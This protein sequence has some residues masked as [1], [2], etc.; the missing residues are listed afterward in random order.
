VTFSRKTRDLHASPRHEIADSL[1]KFT[2]IIFAKGS[3][4][5]TI[6]LNLLMALWLGVASLQAHAQGQVVDQESHPSPINTF[7]EGVDGLYLTDEPNEQFLQSFIPSLSAIDF[8]AM[9]FEYGTGTAT[10]DVNLYEG[11]PNAYAATLLGTTTAVTMP[12]EFNNNGLDVAGVQDFH[13]T[14]PIT[15]TPGDTYY[16]EPILVSGGSQWSFVTIIDYN[17]YPNGELY[18]N[19]YPFVNSTEIWFKEGIEAVPE[20]TAGALTGVAC[21]VAWIFRKRLKLPKLAVLVFAGA[22]FSLPVLSINA[23]QDSVVQATADAA[24]LTPVS[25]TSPIGTFWVAAVNPNGGGCPGTSAESSS[26]R[27]KS[28]LPKHSFQ[29]SR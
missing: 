27:T 17:T 24:G 16:L 13:F 22:L 11:S 28:G 2:G 12:S 9:E 14:T 6:I 7:A 4:M 5:K 26:T 8:V 19:G 20:P 18:V 1:A 29:T 23:S 21:I 25:T 15:L 10:V 3:S